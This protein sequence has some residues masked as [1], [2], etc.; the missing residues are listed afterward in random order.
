MLPNIKLRV[1]IILS[2]PFLEFCVESSQ[3]WHFF[4]DF[5]VLFQCKQ[6]KNKHVNTKAFVIATQQFSGRNCALSKGSAGVPIFLSMTVCNDQQD[7]PWGQGVVSGVGAG[8][9]AH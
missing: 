7:Q 9:G 2:S 5:F 6:K 4:S 1:P 3:I 8:D